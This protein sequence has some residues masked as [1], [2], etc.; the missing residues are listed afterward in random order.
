MNRGLYTSSSND[1]E[2]PQWLFDRL[3]QIFTFQLDACASEKNKKCEKYFSEAEDGLSQKWGGGIE[4]GA[5]PHMESKYQS[6]WQKLPKQSKIT[7]LWS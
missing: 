2:T 3:N 7:I 6:G 4:H 1:W 5:I